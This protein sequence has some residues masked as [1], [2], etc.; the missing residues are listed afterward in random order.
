MK[1]TDM[2]MEPL[3]KWLTSHNAKLIRSEQLPNKDWMHW[4]A[5]YGRVLILQEFEGQNGWDVYIPVSDSNS[6]R[7]T[8]ES[9]GAWLKGKI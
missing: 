2:R 3:D 4:Y 8:V 1:T 6:I 9:L 7:H 5:L